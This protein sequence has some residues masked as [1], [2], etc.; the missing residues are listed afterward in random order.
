M[1][2]GDLQQIEAQRQALLNQLRTA[3]ECLRGGL[4]NSQGFG[5][6]ARAHM[7]RAQVHLAEAY[8]AINE[9]KAV[10]SVT[11]LVDDLTRVQQV[12]EQAKRRQSYR[13]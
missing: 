2:D 6:T 4:H 3:E 1:S 7:E 9:T 5:S 8:I 10:R 12:M 13:I 11:Q